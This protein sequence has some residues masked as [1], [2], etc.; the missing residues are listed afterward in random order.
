M[1][2]RSAAFRL[3][4]I[5]SFRPTQY[6]NTRY[7]KVL[8]TSGNCFSLTCRCPAFLIYPSYLSTTSSQSQSQQS[9][10][11][12]STTRN[13]KNKFNKE[14][15]EIINNAVKRRDHIQT[16]LEKNK[17]LLREKKDGL[18]KDIRDT[19]T[20]VKEKMEVVIERE[21]V[22]TIPNLLC[23]GRAALAPYLGYVIIQGDYSL[24]MGLLVAAGISDLLD[25]WIARGWPSQASKMGSFL[26]PMADKLLVG[27]LCI[28]LSYTGLLPL[29]LTVMV[30]FRD[31]FLILAGFVIRY[32]SLPPPVI[33]PTRCL[34]IL[35]K[36]NIL[37]R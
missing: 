11:A 15:E 13:L 4:G 20:K 21:N 31:A 28:C 19:K 32:I 34:S 16:V 5:S 26:D 36:P 6:T 18:V 30:L 12:S 2:I 22:M 27:S 37:W 1:M 25:G 35:I 24:A 8:G 9:S 23:V 29:W 10:T 17:E 33:Y 3:N 7:Y 14:A